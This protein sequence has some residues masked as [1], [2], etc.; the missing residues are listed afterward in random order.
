M[1]EAE[2]MTCTEPARMLWPL[3]EPCGA[4]ASIG[5]GMADPD[6]PHCK[7]ARHYGS[8]RRL[9]PTDRKQRLFAIGFASSLS[10]ALDNPAGREAIETAER[11]VEGVASTDEV[12]AVF[13]VVMRERHAVYQ[14]HP[15]SEIWHAILF[16]QFCL[17]PTRA[18]LT[19][20]EILVDGW[21]TGADHARTAEL[22]RDIFGSPWSWGKPQL[23]R[24]W[25]LADAVALADA[26]YESRDF[27]RMPILGDALEE[28]GCSDRDVLKHC[29]SGGLHARGCWVVD[30]VLGKG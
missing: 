14:A 10:H 9:K 23:R 28:A 8:M 18:N 26:L 20:R 6:C 17:M 5:D 24:E 29:R 11:F 2:W 15:S 19:T 21:R 7:G 22:A 12:G 13:Q 30:Q 27:G 3:V 25:R 1:T 4:C 16:A